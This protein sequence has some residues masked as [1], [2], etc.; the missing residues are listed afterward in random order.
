MAFGL[1][2][3][4]RE[5]PSLDGATG[6]LN[7]EPLTPEGLRGKV[8]LVEFCTFSCVNW[9]R[10]LPY[11]R[12]W[13]DRYRDH[14]LVVIGAHSPEFA[15]EHDA[16]KVRAA[17]ESMDVGFPIAIDSDFGVWRAFENAYWPALYFAGADGR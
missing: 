11:V 16:E 6:W 1:G 7:S 15:F 13:S 3:S 9:L 4:I 10:T 14:G 17:L 8:V 2:Q 5:L 12:A